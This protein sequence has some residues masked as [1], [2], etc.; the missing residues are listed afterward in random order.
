[1]ARVIGLGG[2]FAHFKGDIK[3]LFDWYE[4]NL[5]LDFS[6]YGSGF[7]EEEQLLVLSFKRGDNPDAPYLN[8]R[9]DD[10]EEMIQ[11]LKAQ[12][13]EII[14]DIKEYDYGKFATIKDPFGNALELWQA[15]SERYKKM[16][17][18]ELEDFKKK[19]EPRV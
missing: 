9:V 11:H 16:V 13:I 19:K 2:V 17:E 8:F 15:Y 5:G 10:L 14:D 12:D 4:R 6:A 1:M 18:N 3:E 7:I